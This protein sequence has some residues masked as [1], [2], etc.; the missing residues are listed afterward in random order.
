MIAKLLCK[1]DDDCPALDAVKTGW[2]DHPWFMSGET[3]YG[4]KRGGKTGTTTRW[5]IVVC[6]DPDCPAEFIV[7][8]DALEIA[9]MGF[10][11]SMPAVE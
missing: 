4:D 2:W 5:F 9:A 1:H 11:S 3:F 6:N 10:L 7:K 8:G